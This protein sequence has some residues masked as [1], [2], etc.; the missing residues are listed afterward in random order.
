M[1]CLHCVDAKTEIDK[2]ESI[3]S[4]EFVVKDGKS[5][6]L[7]ALCLQGRGK[8]KITLKAGDRVVPSGGPLEYRVT[9]QQHYGAIFVMAP[10][11]F[12][13]N[14]EQRK[15]QQP[16]RREVRTQNFLL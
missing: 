6:E 14:F 5:V 8:V 3:M 12:K 13:K 10:S 1:R 7:N 4:N 11:E 15:E 9:S 2:E 16:S